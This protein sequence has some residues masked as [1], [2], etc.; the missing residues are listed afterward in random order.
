MRSERSDA[1]QSSADQLFLA[2]FATEQSI[3]GVILVSGM[4][5]VA[6]AGGGTSW[7]VFT[8]VVFTVIVF[9]AAHVYAG[10]VAQHNLVP[11]Q[12]SSLP[13]SFKHSLLQSY[14]LLTSAIVPSLVLLLGATEAID[15]LSAIWAALWTGVAVLAVL[16]YRAFA[17]RGA[18]WW[19][20]LAGAAGTAT[21]GIAMIL[22]KAF[23][24]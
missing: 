18:P 11:G 3:Y 20:R 17:R 15:D 6:G 22:L 5:V 10:T 7:E 21:F 14:G 1:D 16:G 19:A 4:V 9:W 8:T 2:T 24:H 12:P 13:D 23:I